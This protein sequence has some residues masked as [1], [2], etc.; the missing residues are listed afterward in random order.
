MI[1]SLAPDEFHWRLPVF[2]ITPITR[3]PECIRQL[4]VA[5]SKRRALPRCCFRRDEKS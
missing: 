3:W 5:R 1:F 2:S 4:R